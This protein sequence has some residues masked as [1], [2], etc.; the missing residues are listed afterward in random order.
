MNEFKQEA[1]DLIEKVPDDK[2]EAVL[3]IL[4]NICELFKVD[5]NKQ[6]LLTERVE[7]K[8]AIMEEVEALVGEEV[9][10]YKK[11]ED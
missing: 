5:T 1:I 8:L 7:E 4:K 10:D 3:N 11:F 2:A 9:W 6:E